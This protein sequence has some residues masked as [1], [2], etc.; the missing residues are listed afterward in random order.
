MTT[1][2]RKHLMSTD[3]FLAWVERQPEQ[4][5]LLEGVPVAMSPGR[6]IHGEVKYRVARAL[7]EAI[8]KAGSPCRFVLDSAAALSD[9]RFVIHHAR[10]EGDVIATRIVSDLRLDP[11]GIAIP[12]SSLFAAQP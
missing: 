4:W 5:E 2:L 3:E 10:G 1:A 9:R 11:P 8:A 12:V 6:V 7:D